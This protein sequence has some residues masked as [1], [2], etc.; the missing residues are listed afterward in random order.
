MLLHSRIPPRDLWPEIERHYRHEGLCTHGVLPHGL[1]CGKEG[2][3]LTAGGLRCEEH[4]K[5]N[6]ELCRR[7]G[8]KVSDNNTLN[9][10]RFSKGHLLC[11]LRQALD[12]STKNFRLS[13]WLGGL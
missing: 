7:S 11:H 5:A 1:F 9:P 3:S 8:P 10:R 2:V 4:L 12:M 6:Y 13:N